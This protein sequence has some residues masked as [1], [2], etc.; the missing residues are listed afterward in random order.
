MHHNLFFLTRLLTLGI[1]FSTAVNAALVGKPEILS[2]LP[3]ISAV[4]ALQSVFLTSSLV[5]GAFLSVSL[6]FFSKSDLTMSYL[7]FK[8]N[9]LVLIFTFAANLS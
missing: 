3:S 8:T 6:I 5:L 9:P 4:L 1:L 2:I 7:V